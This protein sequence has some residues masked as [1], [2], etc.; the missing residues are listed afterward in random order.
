MRVIAKPALV[1]FWKKHPKAKSML[2]AW[3]R[4]ACHASW[5]RPQDIKSDHRNASF[6]A[7]NR[8]VFNIN[9]YRLVVSVAYKFDAIYIK[10]IGTHAEYDAIDAAT[11]GME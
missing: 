5:K 1:S 8:V 10:F 4:E 6:L 7:N 11:V 2:E 3:Y 9:E